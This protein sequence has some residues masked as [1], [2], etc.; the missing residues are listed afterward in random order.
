M[1]EF[2]SIKTVVGVV[3]ITSLVAVLVVWFSPPRY[4]VI[5]KIHAD[6]A[7]DVEALYSL[8]RSQEV[9]RAAAETSDLLIDLEN[10]GFGNFQ[11]I[12]TVVLDSRL[13]TLD[14]K[15][16]WKDPHEAV[17]FVNSILEIL[18][19][20]YPAPSIILRTRM[21]QSRLT[22]ELSKVED[23]I[24][25]IRKELIGEEYLV[26]TSL[27]RA[28]SRFWL[29][30]KD[31]KK[32]NGEKLFLLDK[33]M[34]LLSTPVVYEKSLKDLEELEF[35]R[36]LIR[37]ILDEFKVKKE[38]TNWQILENA[39]ADPHPYTTEK[40]GTVLIASL[41]ALFGSLTFVWLRRNS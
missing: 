25:E 11:R 33:R 34:E 14:L 4:R 18:K 15:V 36:L 22:V 9:I 38:I 12:L 3:F 16:V 30:W 10:R 23:R 40:I 19:Q 7:S 2:Y 35:K 32:D 41:L 8:I 31:W 37:T 17:K 1:N 21:E 27:Q 20:N 26:N 39:V 6:F 5:A 28:A 24:S 13:N 29:V